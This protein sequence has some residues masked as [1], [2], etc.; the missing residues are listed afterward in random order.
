MTA[1]VKK[2]FDKIRV[3]YKAVE[4]GR[5]LCP[6]GRRDGKDFALTRDSQQALARLPGRPAPRRHRH[7]PRDRRA[8]RDLDQ[9]GHRQDP[10][11]RRSRSSAARAAPS[12]RPSRP[13]ATSSS[14]SA[15]WPGPRPS[16]GTAIP[17]GCRTST[18][19][20]SRSSRRSTVKTFGKEAEVV[21]RPRRA[22]V[23]HHR[24]E[25]PGHGH[26]LVRADH[27]EPAFARGARPH[28]LGREVLEVPDDGRRRP[29]VLSERRPFPV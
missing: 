15:P 7:A 16:S 17:A 3:E 20:S 21:G 11:E 13:P 18:R 8:D 9:P 28:R 12:P 26:D 22:R 25:V 4:P 14:P 19:R 29:V 27:E 5:D 1:A 10:Q 24:R 2:A 6:R 23:R